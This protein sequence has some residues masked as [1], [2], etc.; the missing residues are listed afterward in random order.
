MYKKLFLIFVFVATTPTLTQF[1]AADYTLTNGSATETAWAMY[2]VWHPASD[3][4]PKGWRTQGWYEI[5]PGASRNLPIPVWNTWVYIRVENS[6]G[7]VKPPDHATRDSS[8][9][10]IH[11]L[12]AFTVVETAEGDFLKSDYDKGSLERADLYEY[13]N[14]GSHTIAGGADQNLPDLPA[15]QIY[16]QAMSSVV[17]I[18]NIEKDGRGSGV[19]IDEERKLVVTNQ[20]VTNNANLVIVCFPVKNRNGELIGNRDYYKRNYLQ[21]GQKGYATA[22]RVIAEDSER[23]LAILQ[24]DFLRENSREI[25]HNFST[26]LSRN[27]RKNEVIHLMGNPGST[28]LWD[29]KLGSFQTDDGNWVH[30]DAQA[31]DGRGSSG[32][33]VLNAQGMLIGIITRGDGEGNIL[34]M[35]ARYVNNLLD[36]VAP[37]HTFL[38]ENDTPFTIYYQIKWTEWENW[39]QH[40]VRPGNALFHW[41]DRIVVS[42]GFPRIR[43]DSIVG[44]RQSTDRVYKLDAFLRYFGPNYRDHVTREDAYAYYFGYDGSTN[45]IDLYFRNNGCVPVDINQDGVVD[46]GD[47]EFV[48]ERLGRPWAR[49]ADVDRD[50]DVDVE[51]LLFVAGLNLDCLRAGAPSINPETLPNLTVKNLQLWIDQAKQLETI[52]PNTEKGIQV[53]EQLLTALSRGQIAPIV[54]PKE[55]ELLANYPNPFNPETWIPYQL[56]IP[57]DVSISIYAADGK[58]VRMLNLGHQPVGIYHQRS[59]A[60]YWDGRNAQGEPVASGVYFYTLKAGDFTATRKMLIRK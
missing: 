12:Q 4:W 40:S 57:A 13:R 46:L 58:L 26:D 34:A 33:P 51:D 30:I 6:N 45:R 9:F 37:K 50:G 32:G 11:P 10:W 49:Q 41:R 19:L 36:T 2:S 15:Q 28:D 54:I 55:T 22:A 24:L 35:P 14:G 16:D 60:A 47:L 48:A 8:L 3:G 59:R 25:N 29:W 31:Y 52:T 18:I 38:I 42:Q 21:L 5:A 53:L 27:V 17:W 39:N 43:F 56:A 7:E 20:H 44:N 1:A 23:D